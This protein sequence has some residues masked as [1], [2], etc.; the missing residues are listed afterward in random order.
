MQHSSETVCRAAA[1]VS[2]AQRYQEESC[3]P[4]TLGRPWVRPGKKQKNMGF[5]SR[6]D[7][8]CTYSEVVVHQTML[9]SFP[10]YLL[11]SQE[12]ASLFYLTWRPVFSSC[13]LTGSQ[14]PWL[15]IPRHLFMLCHVLPYCHSQ[16]SVFEA[17][18]ILYPL[19]GEVV[20]ERGQA[21]VLHA[22]GIHFLPLR[23]KYVHAS[24]QDSQ[25]F[26]LA[27]F[28]SSRNYGHL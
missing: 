25:T 12:P 27:G 13:F 6:G 26:H 2:S 14:R 24:V 22:R 4:P 8:P 10:S 15:P 9:S 20:V 11:P 18:I 19:K 7:G 28:F 17:K 23:Q 1:A 21:G 16:P 5:L 3:L